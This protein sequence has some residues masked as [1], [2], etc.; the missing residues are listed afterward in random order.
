MTAKVYNDSEPDSEVTSHEA[1]LYSYIPHFRCTYIPPPQLLG[2]IGIHSPMVLAS[3][4]M[5]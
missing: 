2:L 1:H 4:V 3:C 5:N